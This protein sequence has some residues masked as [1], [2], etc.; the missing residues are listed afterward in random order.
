MKKTKPGIL[1]HIQG[2]RQE[3]HELEACASICYLPLRWTPDFKFL[4]F[5]IR[6]DIFKENRISLKYIKYLAIRG[7]IKKW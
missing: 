2:G 6:D 5:F 1:V 3:D 7:C 4:E